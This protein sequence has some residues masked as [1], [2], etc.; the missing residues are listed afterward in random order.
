MPGSPKAGT[1][2]MMTSEVPG[3]NYPL[4]NNNSYLKTKEAKNDVHV[5]F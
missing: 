1:A 3:F 5:S 2:A 4:H